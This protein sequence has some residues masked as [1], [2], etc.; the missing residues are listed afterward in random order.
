LRSD[1]RKVLKPRL[2]EGGVV[3]R[4]R[5]ASSLVGSVELAQEQSLEQ[6]R[7]NP[8]RQKNPGRHDTQHLGTLLVLMG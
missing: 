2:R 4:E 8:Y 6:A 5:E 7:D 3:A 1:A